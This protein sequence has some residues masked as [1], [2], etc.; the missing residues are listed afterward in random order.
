MGQPVRF[1]LLAFCCLAL[2]LLAGCHRVKPAEP[3][4]T[5]AT[6]EPAETAVLAGSCTLNLAA[7]TS[8]KDQ[9]RA[10]LDAEG[11]LVV[12]Q[13]ID[14]LMALWADGSRIV[15]AKN[16]PDDPSDDQEWLDKDAVRHRY[17]R[18]VFPGAPSEASPANLSMEIEGQSAT[19]T[20]TTQIGAEVS[21]GGDRWQLAQRDGCW[22]IEQLTYNLEA[23]AR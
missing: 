7:N 16:T 3:A 6:A 12:T 10:V 1:R 4:A 23:K 18:I 21:P 11:E 15:D 13:Q 2:A 14:A 17:V 5:A 22:V 19:V 20:S 9:I 8:D